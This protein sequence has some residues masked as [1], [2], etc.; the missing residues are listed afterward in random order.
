MARGRKPSVRYWPSRKGGGYF[1]TINGKQ[2]E[3]ALGPKDDPR[4]PTYLAALEAF[5]KILALDTNKG[6]SKYL[7]SALMNQ[8]RMDRKS[9]GKE[10]PVWEVMC[11]TFAEQFG[12]LTVGELRPYHIGQWLA[13]RTT[14]NPTT[15]AHGVRLVQ[16]ALNWAER[17][18]VIDR[19]PLFRRVESPRA[20]RR[21]REA[22]M[23]EELCSLLIA[24]AYSQEMKNLLLV[25]RLTGARPAEV[26]MAEAHNFRPGK[27]GLPGMLVY[28]ANARKGYLHKTAGKTRK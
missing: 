16:A 14:W 22:R 6:T 25:L 8:Y 7:V 18:G 17:K 21:G 9:R 11:K 12:G 24:N 3:L 13:S 2:E 23:S 15:Q 20:L 4:G 26:H 19:N 1:A 5:K 27:G 10:L 28:S